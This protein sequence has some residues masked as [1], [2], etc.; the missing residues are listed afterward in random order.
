M[1]TPKQTNEDDYI[2]TFAD[3][4]QVFRTSW[5]KIAFFGLLCGLLSM[6]FAITRPITY[7]IHASFKEKGQ[8]KPDLYTSSIA[9]L[10]GS[11]G[12]VNQSEAISWMKSEKLMREMIQ[13]LDLQGTIQPKN[14]QHSLFATIRDNL[15]VEYALFK[16]HPTPNLSENSPW[17][18]VKNITYKEEL[19]LNLEIHF[20]SPT[21]YEVRDTSATW[22]GQG[23]LNLPFSTENY[24]FTL[25]PQTTEA[26]QTQKY[27][28]SLHPLGSLAKSLAQQIHFEPDLKDKE[29]L[30]LSFYSADRKLGAQ[31]LNTL[32]VVYKEHQENEQRRITQNQINYLE[33]RQ[34]ETWVK[35]KETMDTYAREQAN[36]VETNGFPNAEV[37]LDFLSAHQKEQHRKLMVIDLEIQR[38]YQV[39]DE[40]SIYYDRYH[41]DGDPAVI[42]TLLS[43]IRALKQQS[44]SIHLT[45]QETPLPSNE[46]QNILFIQQMS[47]LEDT[48]QLIAELQ[49]LL[50]VIHTDILPHPSEKLLSDSRFMI[51][52][53]Q[54]KLL[55]YDQEREL[56]KLSDKE[57]EKHKTQYAAYLTNL[58]QLFQVHEKALR[59]RIA[60][61]GDIEKEFRGINLPLATELFLENNRQLNAIESQILQYQFVLDKLQ[62]P[63]FELNSLQSLLTDPISNQIIT[64]YSD[65]L[66]KLRDEGHVSARE[67]ERIRRELVLQRSFLE[68]HIAQTIQV[69]HL[70][71]DMLRKKIYSLQKVS[72]ALIQQQISLLEKQLKDYLSNRISNL[73]HEKTLV[74]NSLSK[75]KK[76]MAKIPLRWNAEQFIKQQLEMNKNFGTELAQLVESKN[77]VSNMEVSKSTPVD[78]ATTPLFPK[79][80][81]IFLWFLVGAL[82]GSLASFSV[83][84][85]KQAQKGAGALP[86]NLM[87]L[88]LHVSGSLSHKHG[89]TLL[90]QDLSTY[91][92]II[93]HLYNSSSTKT[94]AMIGQKTADLSKNLAWLFHKNGLKTLIIHA[95]FDA[96]NDPKGLLSYLEGSSDMPTIHQE[97]FYDVIH[98]GNF[99]RFGQELIHSNRFAKLLETHTP[100]YDRILI[101]S[102][103]KPSSP[104]ADG[105]V[106]LCDKICVTLNEEMTLKELAP[107][108][109]I[110]RQE[111]HKK[112][113]FLWSKH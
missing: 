59:E 43:E 92:R 56:N 12:S 23:E 6:A 49:E 70:T 1:D 32:M 105:L 48:R 34:K 20:I 91:R 108:I 58:V 38:L 97:D 31:I 5:K 65:L 3:F 44:D 84:L 7:P 104:E 89:T 113:T 13:Q 2:V 25:V 64:T 67:Q 71:A 86:E 111:A 15:K 77:I 83:L 26:P 21:T 100:H 62:N 30:N 17:L 36:D 78:P 98:C 80:P 19:P 28:L 8:A 54:D 107:L 29:L 74:E 63:D 72:L 79:N 33:Q 27:L 88:G 11:A 40:G 10:M 76:E 102:S 57:W 68:M 46:G 35:L 81:R 37:A 55:E 82:L 103:A 52:S 85:F 75:L 4:K 61:Q 93:H 18:K 109:T 87:A 112:I 53:W 90:D 106:R 96:S 47:K 60:H 110:S 66:F 51:K 45:L 95:S 73:Q 9:V 41:T 99:S 101:V 16:H 69:Q 42:N 22:I 50:A 14:T 94:M 39:L 24:S